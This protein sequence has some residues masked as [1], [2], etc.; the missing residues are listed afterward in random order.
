MIRCK[1]AGLEAN[2]GRAKITF[3]ANSVM[4]VPKSKEELLAA[5]E[6]NYRKLRLELESIPTSLIRKGNMPGHRKGTI[7]NA[8]DLVAYLIGWGELVLKWHRIRDRGQEPDFPESNFKW[9]ELGQLAQ[10]FYADYKNEDFRT[11][12]QRLDIAKGMIVHLVESKT[13]R[14]L[15]GSPWY[16]RCTMGKMIQL[17]TASPYRNA[18]GRIRRWKKENRL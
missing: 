3:V 6:S 12:L 2:G 5:I 1:S 13:D 15:Y 10:K 7:M 14:Q 9:T 16:R 18:H 11:L 4:P 17:N 8:C